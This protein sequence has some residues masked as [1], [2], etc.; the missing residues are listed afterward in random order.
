MAIEERPAK[1]ED[2]I[3]TILLDRNV[4]IFHVPGS[5]TGH[6]EVIDRLLESGDCLFI[7]YKGGE[8][9]FVQ[10]KPTKNLPI[11]IVIS[12][13]FAVKHRYSSRQ[14]GVLQ[15]LIVALDPPGTCIGDVEQLI[16][17]VPNGL[18]PRGLE[19]NRAKATITALTESTILSIEGNAR[20]IFLE[21]CI[22]AKNL[23]RLLALKLLRRSARGDAIQLFTL[24]EAVAALM[25]RLKQEPELGGVGCEL[26]P[27]KNAPKDWPVNYRRLKCQ[28]HQ[29][30]LADALGRTT[31]AVGNLFKRLEEKKMI[32]YRREGHIYV[33]EDFFNGRM[34][35]TDHLDFFW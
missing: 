33:S 5:E 30:D 8:D 17:G 16:Y 15:T 4:G 14:P 31:V 7:R 22:V 35:V 32:A 28:I 12:G 18:I 9:L 10:G 27:A 19:A 26:R 1:R 20:T 3:D 2:I 24:D 21:D 34:S 6:L 29:K 13:L 25:K 23:N 11:T